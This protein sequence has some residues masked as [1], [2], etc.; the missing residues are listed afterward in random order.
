MGGQIHTKERQ[1]LIPRQRSKCPGAMSGRL[2]AR[3]PAPSF[4]GK[5]LAGISRSGIGQTLT[6]KLGEFSL[7]ASSRPSGANLRPPAGR[8]I[9]G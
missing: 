5:R 6:L 8:D 2:I 9:V 7:V 4:L 3:R 1:G